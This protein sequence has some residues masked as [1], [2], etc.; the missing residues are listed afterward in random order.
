M[1]NINS[2]AA[3]V[4][5][6]RRAQGLQLG[7]VAA[8]TSYSASYLSKLLHG[9]RPLLPG[10][11]HEI[12][13]ALGAEGELDRLAAAQRGE[14]VPATRPV[15][16]PPAIPDF[17]GRDDQL[18][19]MNEAVLAPSRPGV[20]VSIVVEGGFWVGK[21]A[22][23]VHWAARVLGRFPGGCLFADLRGL[24]PGTPA[25]PGEVLDGFL[26]AFGVSSAELC[27]SSLEAR[28]ARYRSLL[29]QRPALVV[30][31]NVANYEQVK[32]LLP[33]AG[34]VVVLTSREHQA[35]LLSRS[36]ALHIELPPLTPEEGIQLL[37]RR[38]GTARV[39]VDPA[40]AEELVHRCGRLPMPIL[41]AA[42]HLQQRH[43][44]SLRQLAERLASD[45][46]RLDLFTSTDPEVNIHGVIDL[47]YLALPPLAARVF[48]LLGISPARTASVESTAALAELDTDRAGDALDTLRQAH[49]LDQAPA[50]RFKVNYL[51]HAYARQR[52]V[53]EEHLRDV[54]RVHDRALWWYAASAW[55]ANNTLIPGWAGSGFAPENFAG[56]QAMSFPAG[57]FDAAMAWC[58]AEVDTALKIATHARTQEATDALWLLPTA[59]LPYFVLTRNWTRWL[60]AAT[61]ALAVAEAAGSDAGIARSSQAL[62]WAQ[63]ELGRTD[64]GIAHLT[65]AL[66]ML[67]QLDDRRSCAWTAY[68]L[69][70]AYAAI[71]RH[72][73]ARAYH[74]LADRLFTE[75]EMPIGLAV[76]R[77]M[78]ASVHDELGEPE[79]ATR[80]A[81]EALDLAQGL[82]STAV[83][84]LAYH[85]LGILLGRRGE[86]RAALTHLDAA[87]RLRGKDWQK[88]G[89]AETLLARAEVLTA[90][91]AVAQA[92]QS[93]VDALAILVELGD[94]RAFDVRA[95]LAGLDA[96]VQAS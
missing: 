51:L 56:L 37:G 33:A 54:E 90:L 38:V 36:G 74:R 53:V 91:G 59:F 21:T 96:H 29:A 45:R 52:G 12:D 50:G 48:R 46:T 9:H 3:A 69:A 49:L 31:D 67:A 76:N 83:E 6:L 10:A 14:G 84:S 42:E 63:C 5:R 22:L 88:W 30:L 34:S 62:G 8:R 40:A 81:R 57:G 87:L 92:R 39:D 32:T 44:T 18:R 60:T 89:A 24:A 25:E 2:F 7:D 79:T 4:H 11:V 71:R 75:Y 64:E 41:I 43:A 78:T 95:R 47:S 16:L 23:A 20:C 77:A 65:E 80:L 13:V 66:Q 86:H 94:P 82:S 27:I 17:V 1:R 35:G 70:R 72:A 26:Q 58:D 73:H 55:A 19:A 15:Q 61:N 93:Y 85:R 28:V 68:G